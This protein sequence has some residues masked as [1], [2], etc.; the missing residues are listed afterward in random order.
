MNRQT[1][2]KVMIAVSV[3]LII[4]SAIMFYMI[5]GESISFRCMFLYLII[6]PVLVTCVA[7]VIYYFVEWLREKDSFFVVPLVCFAVTI[8]TLLIGLISYINDHNF[9]LRGLGAQMLWFFVS[10]PSFVACIIQ[11]IV[12]HVKAKNSKK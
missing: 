1:K 4:V 12:F 10:L 7:Y 2:A 3:F 6:I 11:I 9:I 5:L 8:I